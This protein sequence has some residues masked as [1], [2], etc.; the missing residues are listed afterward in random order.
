[1]TI[2]RTHQ[3]KAN[4]K[5][6]AKQVRRKVAEKLKFDEDIGPLIRSYEVLLQAI[7]L[8]E[9]QLKT[10]PEEKAWSL[11]TL[12]DYELPFETIPFIQLVQGVQLERDK[13]PISIREAKW[14]SRFS[15]FYGPF[16]NLQKDDFVRLALLARMYAAEE[17]RSLIEDVPCETLEID[18]QTFSNIYPNLVQNY[19]RYFVEDNGGNSK[20]VKPIDIYDD[21]YND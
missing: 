17:R 13:S 3:R 15:I 8:R 1:M 21:F 4:K 18:Q 7:R 2:A 11:S 9:K 19:L 5:Y 14:I 12:N 20:S 6:S 16:N 10:D